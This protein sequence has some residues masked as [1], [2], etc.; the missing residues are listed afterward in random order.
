MNTTDKLWSTDNLFLNV[1]IEYVMDRLH[2]N[3][4]NDMERNYW[5]GRL[6]SLANI[7]RARKQ[8]AM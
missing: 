1:E 4:G 3:I 8:G 5:Q 2:L 6:D 7:E